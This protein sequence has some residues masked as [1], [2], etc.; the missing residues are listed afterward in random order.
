MPIQ[1]VKP[2]P[3]PALPDGA[4]EQVLVSLGIEVVRIAKGRELVAHCP[5][6]RDRDGNLHV[7]HDPSWSIN[8]HTGVHNCF[9]CAYSGTLSELVEDIKGEASARTLRAELQRHGRVI[10]DAKPDKIRLKLKRSQ[11]VT[12]PKSEE[13]TGVTPEQMA[14]MFYDP[15]EFALD[16]RRISQAVCTQYA[17]RWDN[18]RNCWILPIRSLSRRRLLGWQIK[19][20]DRKMFL[21]HPYTMQKALGIFMPTELASGIRIGCVESPLDAAR[22][23]E[24]GLL[25][26]AVLGSR[27]S[28]EQ[29]T[30]LG[31]FSKVL[32]GLDNDD[33]GIKETERLRHYLPQK[34]VRAVP[35]VYDDVRGKDPGEFTD[36]TL[37]R[38]IGE[39]LG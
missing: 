5:N 7:D 39:F 28:A 32:L 2:P 22:M 13:H 29:V 16:K 23:T 11:V 4:V 24:H 6:H 25:S 36:R 10:G 35:L 8:R 31:R 14:K 37:D 1:R 21:N 27:L 17:I 18:L 3:L 15:P 33:A 30:Y 26:V 9:S 38:I 12:R 20:E 19:T 34:G